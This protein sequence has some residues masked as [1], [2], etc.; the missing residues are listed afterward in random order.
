MRCGSW[1][2]G[3]FILL[4]L[5]LLGGCNKGT[6][7]GGGGSA[8]AG[9][10]KRLILLTNGDDPFWDAMRSGMED[11]AKDL[12]LDEVNL[13][14]ELD[15][16]D[17]TPKGQVDKLKQYASQTDV[18][19]VAVSVTDAKNVAIA[20]AMRNLQKQG[21]KVITVD[22]DVDRDAARD[23]RFAYLGTDNVTGGKE[24]GKTAKGLR[25]DGGKYVCFVGL[26]SAA[27]AE[28]RVD[29][30]G[31]GA[32]DKFTQL[33]YLGDDM[34]L[35]V[36]QKN[37]RDA[38]DRHPEADTLVGIWAYNAHAIADTVKDRNVRDKTTVVVFDAAPAALKDME[39]GLIDAMVVQN[40]YDM[41]YKAMRLMKALI[42]DDQAT[43]KAMYPTWDAEAKKFT[44]P[45]GDLIIT[46]LKVVVPSDKSPLKQGMFNEDT[47]FL[48]LDNFKAWLTSKKL[49]GS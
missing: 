46:G 1:K 32:G 17:N 44:D 3:F 10:A 30:F 26:K 18:A 48:T 22:S 36:A 43:V 6:P 39:A 37:V 42:A 28:E 4:A 24:L 45:N 2:S 15:K 9:G 47:E 35:N 31:Q 8:N 41:G 5:L 11:A 38:L 25:P 20:D 29:G 13:K 23:A 16:N 40:P 21:V 14:A 12:K 27:N 49:T 33:E 19:G 7:A 34:D